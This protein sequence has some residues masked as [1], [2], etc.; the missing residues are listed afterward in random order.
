M[1]LE[2]NIAKFHDMTERK[3]NQSTERINDF[4]AVIGQ[5]SDRRREISRAK[6]RKQKR[7]NNDANTGGKKK[8][9]GKR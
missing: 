1:I 7:P 8:E 2:K 3:G 5:K 9:K 4:C 6:R